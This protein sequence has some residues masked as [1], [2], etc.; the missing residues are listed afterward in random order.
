MSTI[1]ELKGIII[2][3]V[4]SEN[5]EFVDIEYRR[6][7][8]G[9]VLRVYID[10]EGGVSLK[11]CEIVSEK[12][13]KK[14][15]EVDLISY[16][17]ILEISSPGIYRVLKSE[18]DFLKFVGKRV[19]ISLFSPIKETKTYYGHIHDFKDGKLYLEIAS[20]EVIE[21]PFKNIA[22]AN[23]EPDLS[24]I[25]KAKSLSNSERGEKCHQ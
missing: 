7:K 12:I 16:R 4:E 14:L 2:P 24:E 13:S 21:I 22:K 19:K 1:E 20:G 6:E 23:L 3:V 15:D 17:Y 25:M 18:K 9:L 10:K 5:Y 11:D 8:D